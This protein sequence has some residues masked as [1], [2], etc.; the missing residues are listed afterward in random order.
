ME[1]HN[2]EDPESKLP[3]HEDIMQLA[4]LGELGPIQK[5]LDEGKYTADYKDAENITPLHWAAINNH[6]ALCRFLL[7]QGADVNALGGINQATPAHWAVQKCN[8]YLVNLLLEHGAD[9]NIADAD[10][11]KL[12][13]L[14]TFDGNAFMLLLILLHPSVAIDE[15]DAQGHTAL[16]WA[17]YNRLPAIVDLLLRFG[18][19]IS[20]T[21]ETGFQPLHWA[22]VRGSPPCILKLLENGADRFAVTSTHKT[23]AT[24][25]EEMKTTQAWHRALMES[26]FDDDATVKQLPLPH[27]SFVKTRAFLTNFFFLSVPI[28]FFSA[29]CLQRVAQQVLLWAPSD[30]KHLQ[31]TGL[32]PPAN[33][34]CNL[35]SEELCSLVLRDSFTVVLG[36]WCTL[37]LTWMVMLFVVQSVQIARALTTY[38]SMHGHLQRSSPAAQVITSAITAGTM[39]ASGAS[40]TT[41]GMGP[42]PAVS[43]G[44][45]DHAH[46]HKAGCFAQWK[47]LLGLDTFI[48]TATGRSRPRKRGN[49]FSRGIITNCK[50]FWFDPAPYFGRRETGSAMLDGEVIDYTRMN[51]TPTKMRMRRSRGD[52]ENRIYQSVGTEDTEDYLKQSSHADLLQMRVEGKRQSTI[53]S[54]GWL[55]IRYLDCQPN[56]RPHQYMGVIL[57]FTT[58]QPGTEVAIDTTVYGLSVHQVFRT[59]SSDPV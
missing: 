12:I 40:L 5:L 56:R 41:T 20:V 48:A 49:P 26:G 55:G 42:D 9:P 39:S 51:E 58:I 7:E 45:E 27:M 46:R 36:I 33:V 34:E 13:H 11:Y 53:P 16:M 22:L 2:V 21:D 37:Q 31:R 24:V 32:P 29:Y 47:T 3:L 28:A 54:T 18:A 44:S 6:L 19:G 10:G 43:D 38:E 25:A 57:P 4:R 15:R 14:A 1:S 30:M 23:P 50:D 52:Q 59:S 35:L 8:Y 17:A